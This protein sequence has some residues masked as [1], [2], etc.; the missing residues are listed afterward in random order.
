MSE[1]YGLVDAVNLKSFLETNPDC[2]LINVCADAGRHYRIPGARFLSFDGLVNRKP[3]VLGF[4]PDAASL[5]HV[6]SKLGL[7]RTTPVVAYDD[8]GGGRACRLLWTLD[9]C[10]HSGSL[11]LLNG[12]AQAWQNEGFDFAKTSASPAASDYVV[13]TADLAHADQSWI[14]AHLSGSNT[15]FLDCRSPGEFSGSVVRAS[16]GGHIPGATNVEWT[17]A[18]R[19]APG[20]PLKSIDELKSLYNSAGLKLDSE[21]VTYCHS[22][23]RS[24]HSYFVLKLIGAKH[25]RGYSGSWSDWGNTPDA[26]I[27]L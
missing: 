26:P 12:G 23:Q 27:E 14:R 6:F 7:T 24:A 3:P 13:E 16:R 9:T 17:Q 20:K 10:G 8:E 22:H 21:I 15:Q 4:L 5:S 1:R 25:V 19:E 18:T 2:A 11:N